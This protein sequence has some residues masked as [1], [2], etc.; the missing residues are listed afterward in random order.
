MGGYF[1]RKYQVHR[2]AVLL[3]LGGVAF[4]V[5]RARTHIDQS[6]HIARKPAPELVGTQWINTAAPIT[7]ASQKGKVTLIDFWTFG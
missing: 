4:A 3:L 5:V 6:P 7:L 1:S 2:I